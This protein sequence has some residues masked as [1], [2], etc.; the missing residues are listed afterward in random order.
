MRLVEQAKLIWAG[1]PKN[2]TGAAMTAKYVSLKGYNH[3]T[4]MIQT[5]AWAAG[6]A[7]VTVNEATSI[8]AGGVQAL[9]FTSYW[10]D[11]T[12]SG[13]LV[14]ATVASTFNLD[15]ALKLYVIEIDAASLSA[16][17]DCLTLA[18]AS[19]G[20]NNDFYGVTYILSEPRYAQATP[21]PS[22]VLD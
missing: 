12:L 1:E 14:K 2:Y 22:A 15:T 18:V 21:V 6:T 3:I 10:H 9:T 13:T 4:I 17:Y 8:A 20:A 11:E 16:G 7:A 19:P 5:G